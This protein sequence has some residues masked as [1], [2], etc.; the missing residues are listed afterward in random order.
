MTARGVVLEVTARDD[1][2][3]EAVTPACR[4]GRRRSHE[5]RARRPRVR[6]DGR[7]RPAPVVPVR[8]ARPRG[9]A[10][11][12]PDRPRRP[13]RRTPRG[14]P[15][16]P[17][18]SWTYADDRANDAQPRDPAVDRAVAMVFAARARQEAVASNRGGD[19]DHAG[20]VMA[21]TARRIR[22]YAGKDAELRELA[23]SSRP[24]RACMRP[25]W[26]S[27]CASRRTSRAPTPCAAATR[28]GT[29][30]ARRA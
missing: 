12:G 11:R 29:R 27:R 28:W 3:I 13:V 23:G 1:L 30:G 20:R 21:A 18:S 14:R 6:A 22:S 17:A 19:F 5:R 2:R 15:S 10:H 7:G 16:R 25:R 8:R 4:L 9:G 24:S 26:R